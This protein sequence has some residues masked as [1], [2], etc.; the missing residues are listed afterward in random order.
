ACAR[1]IRDTAGSAAAPAARCRKFR[2]GSFIALLSEKPAKAT[3]HF[4]FLGALIKIVHFALS[5]SI[6]PGS[7]AAPNQARRRAR[8]AR[9]CCN[10]GSAFLSSHG[11]Y[12]RRARKRCYCV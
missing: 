5:A 3:L 11:P 8:V 6:L 2:R 10:S 12:R 1:A 4:A 7:F 9:F